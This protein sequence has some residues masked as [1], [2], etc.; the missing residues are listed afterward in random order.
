MT[1][2]LYDIP[3]QVPGK[4]ISSNTWKARFSLNYKGIP[5]KTEWI[6]VDEIQSRFKELGFNPTRKFADGS[7]M[8]TVP[9]IHDPSTGVYLADSFLIAQYL[10][11][12]YPDTP[13]LLPDGMTGLQ[14]AFE[15]QF[16]SAIAP[17]TQFI[18]Y[19]L[20]QKLYPKDQE[21]IRRRVESGFGKS[22]EE[23]APKGE[24]ALREWDK[25]RDGLGK[26]DGF[27]AKMD[28]KGPFI[29][30][31]KI[32]WGDI[33]LAGHFTW[34][35]LAFGEGSQQWKDISSWHGGRWGKLL[36]LFDAYTAVP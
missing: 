34:M 26:L 21:A 22:L 16:M 7:D 29:L 33:V 30:G 12:T 11:K 17:V 19:P 9:A 13:R 8:Y 2:T 36:K 28:D 25:L 3:A 6:G 23:L 20:S 32:S 27:Y 18:Q 1:I 14:A 15:D 24:V 31:E 10:D 5:Y 35:K 4:A